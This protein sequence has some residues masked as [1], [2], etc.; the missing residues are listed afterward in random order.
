MSKIQSLRE[1]PRSTRLEWLAAN[2]EGAYAMG[3]VAGANTRRYHGLLVAPWGEGGERHVLLPRVEEEI[4]LGGRWVEL[5]ACQYPGLVTP[6]GFE[7]LAAFAAEPEPFWTW[8]IE[9]VR[10]TRRLSLLRQPAGVR[11]TYQA[12]VD[13]PLRVR[14]FTATRGYHALGTGPETPLRFAMPGAVWQPVNDWYRNVEYLEELDRGFPF[15]EDLWCPGTFT[16]SANTEFTASLGE[17]GEPATRTGAAV[18]LCRKPDRLT[19]LAGYPWFT[20]WGRDTLIA[21]PGLLLETGQPGAAR[22]ILAGLLARRQNGLLPNLFV[23]RGGE[24]EYNTIDATLWAF[25]AAHHLAG[26]GEREWVHTGFYP[27]GVEILAAHQRG[28]LFGIGMDPADGLLRGGEETTQLTWM[29]AR[30]QGRP[31]TPR[32]GKPVEINALWYNALRLM[33]GWAG[34]LGDAARQMQYAALADWVARS[35][36]ATYWNPAAGCLFDLPGCAQIRPNQ[37]F[38]AALTHPLLDPARRRALLETVRRH[39]VTPY[40]LRSLAP[41]D[42]AYQGRYEGGP[43]ERDARYHQGTVW[44]WLAAPFA[45]AW[46]REFGEPFPFPAL[47]Q[48]LAQGCLGHVAEI[49]DG[50]TPHERRGAPAQAWSLAALLTLRRLRPLPPAS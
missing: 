32:H 34:E 37:I 19:L 46:A 4:Y 22:E 17:P 7:F 1:Y 12:S 30:S 49:Y 42:P 16:G 3:T 9:G 14:L 27:I 41:A 38:A 35:F 6:R 45:L 29:D 26:A 25:E 2:G 43:A 23:D 11:L 21:L 8:E 18:F 50:D 31:V 20:D 39:L 24:P 15:R 48:E 44:P 33:A 13:C 5:G 36:A 28:T 40:G 47:E 10:V